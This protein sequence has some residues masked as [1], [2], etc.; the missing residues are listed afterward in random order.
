MLTHSFDAITAALPLKPRTFLRFIWR[1]GYIPNFRNPK[2]FNEKLNARKFSSASDVLTLCSDKILVKDY[3]SSIIGPD[4]LIPTYHTAKRANPEDIK[5]V[6][7]KN[8]PIALKPN[9]GS[10]T[11][12]FLDQDSTDEHIHSSCEAVNES[13]RYDHGKSTGEHWYSKISRRI[14]AE[15]DLRTLNAGEIPLDYKFHV[16]G[17][18]DKS[19]QR[20]ILQVDFDRFSNHHRSFFDEELHW[21]P[22]FCKYPTLKTSLQ[23]PS[24]FQQMLDFAKILAQPFTYARIDFYNVYNRIYFGEMTFCHESGFGKFPS[25]AYDLW[26]GNLWNK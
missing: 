15:Q 24:N 10:G 19:K 11:I 4:V 6:I 3:V 1:L 2:T 25:K 23:P 12:E 5:A 21:L 22:I 17:N 7:K 26:I 9:H 13:L 16:F 14:L 8:G 18:R 20:L